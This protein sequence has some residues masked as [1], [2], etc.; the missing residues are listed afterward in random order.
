VI[1]HVWWVQIAVSALNVLCPVR[2]TRKRPSADCTRTASPTVESGE[3]ASIVISTELFTTGA[4][5]T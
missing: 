3:L 1:V 4:E 5:I 2:A